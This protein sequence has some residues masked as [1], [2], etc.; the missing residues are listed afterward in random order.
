MIE[1]FKNGSASFRFETDFRNSL[2]SIIHLDQREVQAFLKLYLETYDEGIAELLFNTKN[3][4]TKSILI[5][6]IPKIFPKPNLDLLVFCCALQAIGWNLLTKF[7][8]EQ[9]LFERCQEC[10]QDFKK[11]INIL[12]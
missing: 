1:C 11:C 5:W 10:V 9:N 4:F 2:I 12:Q 6:S 8:L 3:D 7:D